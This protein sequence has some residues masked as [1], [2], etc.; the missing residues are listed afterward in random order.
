MHRKE[1]RQRSKPRTC[2]QLWANVERTMTSQRFVLEQYKRRELGQARKA[3]A[4][5]ATRQTTR[6]LVTYRM[7]LQDLLAQENGPCLCVL[8]ALAFGAQVSHLKFE[9]RVKL[10]NKLRSIAAGTSVVRLASLASELRITKSSDWSNATSTCAAA[11]PPQPD[12]R[13]EFEDADT[14]GETTNIALEHGEFRIESQAQAGLQNMPQQTTLDPSHSQQTSGSASLDQLELVLP[15]AEFTR[16]IREVSRNEDQSVATTMT[17]PYW[18][19]SAAKLYCML[20]FCIH[21]EAISSLAYKIFGVNVERTDAGLRLSF[22]HGIVSVTEYPDIT[23]KGVSDQDVERIFGSKMRKAIDECPIREME[24][25]AGRRMTE[26]VSMTLAK[27]G[28]MINLAL[29]LETGLTIFR[30]LFS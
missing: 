16:L 4:I 2:S 12:A 20:S 29:G 7:F 21:G 6:E 18:S 13:P 26:C 15:N 1:N 24:I 9:E 28:A 22:P 11:G 17:T 14:I 10:A 3:A 27:E 30:Q 25:I 8:S 5:L 23:L 19:D